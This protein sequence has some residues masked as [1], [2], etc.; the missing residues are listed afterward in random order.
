MG[1]SL[2]QVDEQDAYAKRAICINWF[3]KIL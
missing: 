1:N 2:D 3:K